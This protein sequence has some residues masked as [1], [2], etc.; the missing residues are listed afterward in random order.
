MYTV[1]K[2]YFVWQL[3]HGLATS[4]YSMNILRWK[5]YEYTLPYITYMCWIF[6]VL[7]IPRAKYS[8]FCFTL[9]YHENFNTT[10]TEYIQQIMYTVAKDY[11]VWQLFHGLATSMY[12]MNIL[13]WKFYEYTLPYI[14]YMCWI[15]RVLHILRA[16]Y[17]L[18]YFTLKYHEN[19]NTTN[20][21]TAMV[22]IH[23]YIYTK[24]SPFNS[25]VWGLLRLAPF[26]LSV[27]SCFYKW[28]L[29]I[30]SAPEQER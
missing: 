27:Q 9:K 14:T 10:N 15:F 13:R 2:D 4:M 26:F 17:S 7:H 16:K 6:R 24:N 18:F 25:L 3:F 30:Y 12:S 8:L 1:A 19:F 5:F 21:S 23:I 20:I 29:N 28:W 11:F 22:I